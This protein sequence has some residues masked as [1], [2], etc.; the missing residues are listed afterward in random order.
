MLPVEPRSAPGL[1]GRPGAHPWGPQIRYLLTAASRYSDRAAPT[2]SS[3]R[4]CEATSRVPRKKYREEDTRACLC[5]PCLARHRPAGVGRAGCSRA[6]FHRFN[7]A[8]APGRQSEVRRR[9]ASFGYLGR[10]SGSREGAMDKSRVRV[11]SFVML[12]VGGLSLANMTVSS[13]SSASSAPEARAVSHAD[14]ATCN[15]TLRGR[16]RGRHRCNQ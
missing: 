8:F 1:P 15:G 12:A 10:P 3:G 5:P 11:A 14:S 9:G 13:P 16:N 4:A 6:G 2:T 7:G